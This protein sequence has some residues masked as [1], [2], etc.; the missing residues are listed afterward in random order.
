MTRTIGRRCVP[1]FLA[2]IVFSVT[3]ST[4]LAQDENSDEAEGAARRPS[5]PSGG[6]PLDVERLLQTMEEKMEL[7]QAQWDDIDAFARDFEEK[8]EQSREEAKD[9]IEEQREQMRQLMQERADARESGDEE[10]EREVRERLRNLRPRDFRSEHEEALIKNISE[11]LEE[12]QQKDFRAIVQSIRNPAMDPERV[13]KN[14]SLLRRAV[15]QVDLDEEQRQQLDEL[16]QNYWAERREA[17]PSDQQAMD[18]LAL[19]FYEKVVE[20]LD[21]EQ[22]KQLESKMSGPSVAPG[23]GAPTQR[24][25][26]DQDGEEQAE[27]PQRGADD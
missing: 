16:F 26:S 6:R 24:P 11:V 23:A 10:R 13:K 8:M 7:T 18:D 25:G 12:E 22:R 14:P 5:A 1:V 15:M 20:L 9:S 2:G 3:A 21:E 19:D 27:P 4:M 17:S